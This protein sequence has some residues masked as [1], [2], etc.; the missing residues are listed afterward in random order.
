QYQIDPKGRVLI[1]Q[2]LREKANLEE[3]V[4][5]IGLN[6]HLEVWNTN[7]LNDVLEQNPLTDEEFE[8]ISELSPEDRVE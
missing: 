8:R 1:S 6:N 7:L 2:S 4:T 3:E 5:V